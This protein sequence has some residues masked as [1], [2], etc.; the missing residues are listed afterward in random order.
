M[1]TE[2]IIKRI[3]HHRFDK[4]KSFNAPEWNFESIRN[5]KGEK[6]REKINYLLTTNHKVTGGYF[7]TAIRGYHDYYIFWKLKITQNNP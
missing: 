2:T 3:Y 1:D 4:N 7:T 5:L 6:L